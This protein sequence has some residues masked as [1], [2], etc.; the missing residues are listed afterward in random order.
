MKKGI[1]ILITVAFAIGLLFGC[2]KKEDEHNKYT[3]DDIV[4][5]Y[6]GTLNFYYYDINGWEDVYDDYQTSVIVTKS[7]NGTIAISI[8]GKTVTCSYRLDPYESAFGVQHT[9]IL[10]F[11][12]QQWN[13]FTVAPDNS[14][15]AYDCY[16]DAETKEI[17]FKLKILKHNSNESDGNL[18]FWN[19]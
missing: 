7:S 15:G 2:S 5:S 9:F 13:G 17:Y 11:S 4:G 10:D 16:I 6:S 14:E 3:V 19:F 12:E 18:Y 8:E 1:S